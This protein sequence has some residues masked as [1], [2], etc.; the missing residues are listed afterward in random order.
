MPLRKVLANKL[1]GFD[2]GRTLAYD[3]WPDRRGDQAWALLVTACSR[4]SSMATTVAVQPP[5]GSPPFQRAGL[6]TL[7]PPSQHLWWTLELQPTGFSPVS[8]KAASGEVLWALPLHFVEDR[9]CCRRRSD[10][11]HLREKTTF[12]PAD[13]CHFSFPCA[14]LSFLRVLAPSSSPH[15]DKSP[16]AHLLCFPQ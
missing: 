13:K 5:P 6:R 10:S 2:N 14:P 12:L 11:F 4:L 9:N 16:P 8:I 3:A 15:T 7:S 1:R